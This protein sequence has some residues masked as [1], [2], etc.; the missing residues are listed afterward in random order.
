[1]KRLLFLAML[2]FSIFCSPVL[3]APS[4]FSLVYPTNESIVSTLSFGW[5]TSHDTG[6]GMVGYKLYI[7][8]T[9]VAT[10]G[11]T[12]TFYTLTSPIADGKHRVYVGAFDNA[13]DSTTTETRVFYVNEV[14]PT[15]KFYSDGTL[16]SAGSTI[17]K[18][19]IIKS[20]ISDPLGIS[21]ETIV[22]SIDGMIT[23]PTIDPLS[24]SEGQIVSYSATYKV[25][26]PLDKGPHIISCSAKDRFGKEGTSALSPIH[27]VGDISVT[28]TPKNYPNPFKP[29]NNETTKITYN[30]SDDSNITI[31]IFDMTGNIIKKIMAFAGEETPSGI[32]LGG[33]QGYNEVE[34]DGT[35]LFSSKIG[36]GVYPFFITYSGKIIGS[37]QVAVYD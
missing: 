12:S 9:I 33:R 36:N 4:S 22:L 19:P 25:T 28:S 29:K 3:S 26:T 17:R 24:T 20:V 10:L 34:W 31:M 11:S 21:R 16:I 13:G 37:G 7:D 30:L 8:N 2:I 14:G 27:V 15:F 23:S 32:G 1:M 6:S 18:L 35:S 5:T